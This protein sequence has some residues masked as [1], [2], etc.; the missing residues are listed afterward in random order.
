[1]NDLINLALLRITKRAETNERA[2]LLETFVDIGPL[3]SILAS[4]DH[5][6]LFGRRGAGKTHALLYLAENR[7]SIGDI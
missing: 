5:Q 4:A 6:V 1:M 3:F 7:A 2:K